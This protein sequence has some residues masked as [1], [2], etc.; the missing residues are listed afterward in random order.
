M[1]RVFVVK[2]VLTSVSFVVLLTFAYSVY[3]EDKVGAERIIGGECQYKQYQGRAEIVSITPIGRPAGYLSDRYEVKFRF[4]PN[5]KIEEPLV[6]T[7]GRESLLLLNHNYYPGLDFLEKYDM[8]VG[9]FLDCT[10]KMIVRGTCTPML[11]DFPF[12]S[13][14]DIERN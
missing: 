12:I 13:P 2:A 4:T 8:K 11:F 9:K 3:A 10:L 6:Q 14:E 1:L 5:Q 7:E